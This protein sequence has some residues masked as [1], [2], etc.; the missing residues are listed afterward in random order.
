VY[1][2]LPPGRYTFQVRAINPDGIAGPEPLAVAVVVVPR[3]TQTSAFLLLLSAGVLALALG[4]A[5][6]WSA[7]ARARAAALKREVER[8]MSQLKILS[9]L[10]PMCA[11][12][13]KIRNDSGYWSQLETYIHEH[14]QAD[15]THSICEDCARTVWEE[16]DGATPDAPAVRDDA[17][18]SG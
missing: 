17:P 16:H 13:K 5:W 11:W 7:A 3:F 6:A 12:C 4:G 1:T 15:F 10:L 18:P 14:S 2:A 8:A 9:G